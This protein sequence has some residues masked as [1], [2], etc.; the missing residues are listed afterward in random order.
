MNTK[1]RRDH[2]SVADR[3]D[4][5]IVLPVTVSAGSICDRFDCSLKIILRQSGSFK[6]R[7]Q[8]LP[9]LGTQVGRVG[10]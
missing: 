6:C 9:R 4:T 7:E 8:C 10:Q 1:L 5:D 2:H 3:A